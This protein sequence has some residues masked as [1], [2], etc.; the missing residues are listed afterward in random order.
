MSSQRAL[1]YNNLSVLLDAGLPILRSLFTAVSGLK[2]RLPEVFGVLTKE[3][4]NGGGLAETMARYPRAFP[5][6]DVLVAGAGEA[7][8]NLAE[9]LKLLSHWYGF[10]DRLRHMILSGMMLPFMLIHLVAFLDPAPSLFLGRINIIGFLFRVVEILAFFYVPIAVIFAIV[11][12]TPRAGFFRRRLDSLTLRI[13]VLGQAVQQLALSRYCRVFYML[14]KGG[15]PI[16]QC[17]KK[18]SEY[19]G[20]ILVT[21]MLSGGADSAIAGKPI[22]YGFSKNLP[23]N[24][25]ERWQI[26]EETGELDN[27]VRRLVETTTEKSERLFAELGQWIPKL[28]YW[29]V[30]LFIIASIF[31]NADLIR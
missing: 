1:I 9:S 17:A 14:F 4:S 12:L 23:D 19:T 31:K 26:G 22:S 6:I 15:V 10:C 24:F 11:R 27:V 20:N 16:L 3:V 13:P 8:G 30:S 5:Q 28:V 25:V 18:S 29:L 21:D 7:S 2:G